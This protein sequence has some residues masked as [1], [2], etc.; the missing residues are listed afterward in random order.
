M[1]SVEGLREK[2][3]SLQKKLS[4][5]E[6]FSVK[7]TT[8]KTS[9]MKQAGRGMRSEPSGQYV[10]V[11]VT[12]VEKNKDYDKTF[13]ELLTAQTELQDAIYNREGGYNTLADQIRGLTSGRTSQGPAFN[14]AVQGLN[15]RRNYGSS[16][17]SSRLNFILI[18]LS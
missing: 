7:T 18:K 12:T 13:N 8:G 11:P 1:A 17:L 4:E 15:A 5:M 6:S 14:A 16:D 3:N 9:V 10:S 2:I